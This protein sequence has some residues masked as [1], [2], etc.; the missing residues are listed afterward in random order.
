MINE[1]V[2]SKHFCYGWYRVVINQTFI[3]LLFL[4][5][6]QAQLLHSAE[7]EG[8]SKKHFSCRQHQR[9]EVRTTNE[10]IPQG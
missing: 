4:A 6:W 3:L 8:A 9:L 7:E 2:G 1:G 10:T 5:P